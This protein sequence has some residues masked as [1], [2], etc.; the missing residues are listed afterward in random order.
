LFWISRVI[1]AGR[2]VIASVSGR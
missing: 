2:V 1:S